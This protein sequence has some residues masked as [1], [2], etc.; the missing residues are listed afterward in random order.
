VSVHGIPVS[1]GASVV[2]LFLGIQF[3]IRVYGVAIAFRLAS[4]IFLSGVLEVG[5]LTAFVASI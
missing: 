3:G 5:I 2:A 4:E 1:L